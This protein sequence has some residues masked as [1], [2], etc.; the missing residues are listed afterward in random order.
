LQLTAVQTQSK[1]SFSQ[2]TPCIRK[3]KAFDEIADKN[4]KA[5]KYIGDSI[6]LFVVPTF[7][8]LYCITD[9]NHVQDS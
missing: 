5:I 7:I 4:K 9:F 3:N 2:Y 6:N 1:F 8:L